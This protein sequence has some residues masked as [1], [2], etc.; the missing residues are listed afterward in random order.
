MRNYVSKIL[1]FGEYTIIEGGEALAIPFPYFA[2]RFSFEEHADA[3]ASQ[4]ALYGLLSFLKEAAVPPL[5]L[6]A[7]GTDL[8][9]GMW[10]DSDIPS[11]Y[12]L[13]SSGAVS[14]AVYDRY[15]LN[16]ATDLETLK[17]DLA[18]LECCFHGSSSGIDPLVAYLN[19]SLWVHADKSIEPLSLHFREG[20]GAI[21]LVDTEQ[22]RQ[23]TPLI[24]YFVTSCR[25]AAFLDN[26]VT[27][28]KE[29]VGDAIAAL[30]GSKQQPLLEAVRRISLLQQAHF[31]PMVP[32]S[33]A[34][35]WNKGLAT[36]DFYL[37]IC[38]AGGGGFMLGFA[39]DWE[40]VRSMYFADCKTIK[41]CGLAG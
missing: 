6:E 26:C 35:F 15:G 13:G 41:I 5:D 2:G 3:S 9:R 30:I 16:K 19:R 21:F 23:S 20:K 12:G 38:G 27:P 33:M 36:D 39:A 18:A 28:L 25:S 4:E 8:E 24:D 34:D 37:K 31:G 11:G 17:E 1:L 7:F 40:R 22:P 32:E 29:A 14:A 10:F